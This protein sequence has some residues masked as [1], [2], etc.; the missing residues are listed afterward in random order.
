M[1]KI[2]LTN[3]TLENERDVT[4]PLIPLGMPSVAAYLRQNLDEE[5]KFGYV[6]QKFPEGFK[7]F[8]PDI[9]FMTTMS[10]YYHKSVLVAK[11]F[12]EIDPSVPIMVGGFHISILPYTLS[13]DMDVGVVGEGELTALELFPHLE[14]PNKKIN[15]IVYR[16]KGEIVVTK[17]RPLI[18]NLDVLPFPARDIMKEFVNREILNI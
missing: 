7:K 11:Q 8:K 18:H 14:N 6:N 12:K 2:L 10:P 16:E 1:K 13:P 5:L 15:G 9:V 17:P 4:D 3:P